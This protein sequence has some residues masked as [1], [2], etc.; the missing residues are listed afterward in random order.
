MIASGTITG[1]DRNW[2][3]KCPGNGRGELVLKGTYTIDQDKEPV[4]VVNTVAGFI[5]AGKEETFVIP[6]V[7]GSSATRCRIVVSSMAWRDRFGDGAVEFEGGC[8]EGEVRRADQGD[9]G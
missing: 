9:M 7:A 2:A 8:G 4:Q 6:G 1:Q 3:G 5:A